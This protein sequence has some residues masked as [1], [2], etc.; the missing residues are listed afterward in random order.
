MTPAQ[1]NLLFL[2]AGLVVG[3]IIG[4]WQR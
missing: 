1:V 2:L 4:R 3:V